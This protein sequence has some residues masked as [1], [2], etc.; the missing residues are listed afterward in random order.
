MVFSD[1]LRMKLKSINDIPLLFDDD[2]HMN[3][4]IM[5]LVGGHGNCAFYAKRLP[6][7]DNTGAILVERHG[8]ILVG[9]RAGYASPVEFDIQSRKS[10]WS[11]NGFNIPACHHDIS[12]GNIAYAWS[13]EGKLSKYSDKHVII[14]IACNYTQV[15]LVNL[16]Y[17]G[18]LQLWAIYC[19]LDGEPRQLA[20][21]NGEINEQLVTTNE[22]RSVACALI[23]KQWRECVS[24]PAYMVCHKRLL[25]E[26]YE[27]NT[28]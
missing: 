16:R 3:E 12:P 25:K 20:A 13:S 11:D 18:G 22:A 19:L 14:F 10:R 5:D 23:Q 1:N 28:I 24:N 26:F 2:N 21:Y 9:F 8:D 7:P 6:P 27:Y 4:A 15:E 17:S